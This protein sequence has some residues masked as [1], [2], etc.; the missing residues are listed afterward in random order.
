V[1]SF[2]AMLLALPDLR[3]ADGIVQKPFATPDLLRQIASAHASR[4]ARGA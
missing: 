4:R 1:V 2:F 3:L